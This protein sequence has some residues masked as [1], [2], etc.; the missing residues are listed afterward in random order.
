MIK[1]KPL[2]ALKRLQELF[3]LDKEGQLR[4]RQTRSNFVKAGDKVGTKTSSGHYQTHVDG[5]PYMVHRIVWMLHNQADPGLLQVDHINGDRADNRPCN[6]R[7][8][9]HEQNAINRS[10]K[11]SSNT[12]LTGIY[13]HSRCPNRPYSAK[14][15]NNHLGFFETI[16]EAASVRSNYL[17]TYAG[18]FNPNVCRKN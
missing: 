8:A 13:F 2:P 6:L 15:G 14:V 10:C 9:T 16:K 4:W 5:Q 18:E 3:E 1:P 11:V 12:G 7:L 17:E